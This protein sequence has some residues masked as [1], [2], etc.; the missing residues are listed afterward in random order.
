MIEQLEQFLRLAAALEADAEDGY[1]RLAEVMQEQGHE[2]VATMFAQFGKFSGLHL[3]EVLEIQDNELGQRFDPRLDEPQ[4]PAE[5]SPENPLALAPLVDISARGAIEMA[6]ETERRACDFYSAV[7]GQTSS[8]RVQE[9]A[10]MFAEEEGE[11]VEHLERWLA[12]LGS[13]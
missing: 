9:L 5:H 12:R 10:Q 6:L 11:H 8:A 3:A 4:W 13:A 7:A 2:E 1:R